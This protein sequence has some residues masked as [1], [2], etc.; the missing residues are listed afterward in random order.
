MYKII[1]RNPDEIM[2]LP[3]D[4]FVKYMNSIINNPIQI[5]RIYNV[6]RTNHR[7]PVALID[8]AMS[9]SNLR[10]GATLVNKIEN[11]NH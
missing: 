10:F 8:Q 1:F 5:K 3:Y 2:I 7:R 9:L 11:N 4:D 6:T